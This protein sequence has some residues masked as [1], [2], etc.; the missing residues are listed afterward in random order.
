MAPED[1]AARI[2]RG[3]LIASVTTPSA[4]HPLRRRTSVALD[5]PRPG[6]TP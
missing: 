2:M 5:R 1:R 4:K 6:S 3:G